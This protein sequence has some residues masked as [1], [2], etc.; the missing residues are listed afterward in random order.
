MK[1]ESF[2]LDKKQKALNEYFET[3]CSGNV[4]KVSLLLRKKK[5]HVD[6][7]YSL[8]GDESIKIAD[9]IIP[10]VCISALHHV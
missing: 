5:V 1:K 10:K 2:L 4:K 8:V 6:S 3:V 9:H 7:K